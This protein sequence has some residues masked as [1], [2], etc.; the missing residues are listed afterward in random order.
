MMY[1][2]PDLLHRI[3]DVNARAVTD[4]LNAQIEAGV[5]AVQ[6]FDT[7]GGALAHGK[8]QE[9]SL[10]YVSQIVSG[11]KKTSDGESVPV[12]VFTKG[13]GIWIEDIARCGADCI[14]LDW[15]VSLGTARQS[16]S[17]R[18]SLQGNM[19]PMALFAGEAAIRA[20]A[21]RV[22]DDFGAVGSGG[23]VFNLG[24]GIAQK[25]EPEMVAALVDEVHAYSRIKH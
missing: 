22:I 19:D 6:I 20:E 15:T 18:V 12:I 23:H 8:Y 3:L 21:R 25:T 7:W 11:L 13:G 5:Q 16:V 14:G 2:R 10:K 4:Y 24:H 9:F 17:D 1:E